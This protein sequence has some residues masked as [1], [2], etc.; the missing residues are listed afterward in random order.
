MWI[1]SIAFSSGSQR[2]YTVSSV[3][4][5]QTECTVQLICICTT[6]FYACLHASFEEK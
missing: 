3:A 2:S 1:D 6:V 5:D 4:I